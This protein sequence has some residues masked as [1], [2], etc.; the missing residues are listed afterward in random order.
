VAAVSNAWVCCRSL[1]GNAGSNP[2]GGM[3][4][5]VL[6]CLCDGP[7]PCLEES[8]GVVP[9]VCVCVTL[10]G[11]RCS[12]NPLHLHR[13]KRTDWERKK[14]DPLSLTRNKKHRYLTNY[15]FTHTSCKNIV[16]KYIVSWIIQHKFLF[17]IKVATE[18]L[19]KWSASRNF[20]FPPFVLQKIYDKT[21]TS[22]SV[23]GETNFKY[24]TIKSGLLRLISHKFYRPNID[25]TDDRVLSLNIHK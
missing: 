5:N 20:M 18:V 6:S 14:K 19:G 25:T 11:I 15:C 10:S 1:A 23:I 3:D 22:M 12:S 7:I 16:Q 13:W 24:R 17:H 2:A 4:V 8:S 9:S 21:G